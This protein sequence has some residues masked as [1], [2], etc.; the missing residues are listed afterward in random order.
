MITRLVRPASSRVWSGCRRHALPAGP[1]YHTSASK[2][3][4]D[5]SLG[6]DLDDTVFSKDIKKVRGLGNNTSRHAVQ[7][8]TL[9]PRGRD[10]VVRSKA[11]WEHA[12]D[13]TFIDLNP[14]LG[15]FHYAFRRH[16]YRLL[17]A[18]EKDPQNAELYRQNFR[19]AK[20]KIGELSSGILPH[21]AS[22]LCL[23]CC[24]A[25][26]EEMIFKTLELVAAKP[27]QRRPLVLVMEHT[28]SFASGNQ[29]KKPTGDFAR[30][31]SRLSDMGYN[32]QWRIYD[33]SRFGLPLQRERLFMIAVKASYSS[34]PFEFPNSPYTRA[35]ADEFTVRSILENPTSVSLESLI[36]KGP[37]ELHW[38][39]RPDISRN[40][41]NMGHYYKQTQE[42]QRE[43]LIIVSDLGHVPSLDPDAPF[44]IR[45]LGSESCKVTPN[46]PRSRSSPPFLGIDGDRRSMMIRRLTTRE[47]ARLYGFSD[48]THLWSEQ[49][50]AWKHIA[51]SVSPRIADA[52]VSAIT[53]QY[54]TGPQ[55]RPKAYW[56]GAKDANLPLMNDLLKRLEGDVQLLRRDLSLAKE[57]VI[58]HNTELR[59]L[60]RRLEEMEKLRPVPVG[61]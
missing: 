41:I 39:E 31:Q 1:F 2:N 49:H 45:T 15:G 6:S 29:D 36:Y 23:P 4:S 14:G 27:S 25:D 52:L 19:G 28:P 58:G 43:K 17:C 54:F 10:R 61:S 16:D 26:G 42:N 50:V 32:L 3:V 24:D 44:L 60:R 33:T 47:L 12:S 18:I 46:T 55:K 37:D 11:T 51:Y 5:T 40:V 20:V 22:V 8:L 48:D 34:V 38:K 7:Q 21:F 56:D 53:V 9:T 59:E 30:L 13:R 35:E 57:Q